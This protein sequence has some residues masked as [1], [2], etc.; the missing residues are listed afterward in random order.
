[1]A[2]KIVYCP[3]ACE[4]RIRRYYLNQYCYKNGET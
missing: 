4:R 1:M 3:N 2:L